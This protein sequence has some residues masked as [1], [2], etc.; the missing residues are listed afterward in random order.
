MPSPR[1]KHSSAATRN[2]YMSSSSSF[3]GAVLRQRSPAQEISAHCAL[4]DVAHAFTPRV[5]DTTPDTLLLDLAGLGRLYGSAAAM[6]GD[7]A[8]RVARISVEA[9]IAVA[10]NPDAAMHAARGFAGTT[11]IPVGEEAHRL[12]VLPVQILLDAFEISQDE[13]QRK[14]SCPK[15]R[16][17]CASRCWTHW[18]DGG[19]G[20]SA[21]WVC[22]RSTRWP[23]VSAKPG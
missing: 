17:S 7:L 10:A 11:V 4:L 5:E 6:V 12:G 23:H 9:N 1:L 8:S 22:C 13:G 21:C 19:C 3:K 16:K 14:I 2:S 15:A 20:I 18:S